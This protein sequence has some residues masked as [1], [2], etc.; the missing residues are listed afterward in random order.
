MIGGQF[1]R[2]LDGRITSFNERAVR[3]W[4][5]TPAPD[6]PAERFCGSY[7]LFSP[8]GLP[9]PHD[10]CGMAVA[11]QAER[12]V[13]VEPPDGET[14]ISS[15]RAGPGVNAFLQKPFRPRELVE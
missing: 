6:D 8:E 10:R 2:G 9:V 11:L 4:G 14:E 3:L 13:V 12:E 15:R 5:R 7:K 1:T